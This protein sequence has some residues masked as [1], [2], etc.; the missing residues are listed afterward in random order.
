M[1]TK[2]RLGRLPKA[3]QVKITISVSAE[4][5]ENLDRYAE[6]HSHANGENNDVERLI[7]FMLQAFISADREFCR[8]VASTASGRK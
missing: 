4:L 2:L 7:P 8:A 1:T 3:Q 5:K 6:L